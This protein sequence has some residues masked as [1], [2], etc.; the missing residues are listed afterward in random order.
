M[1]EMTVPGP[2][3]NNPP[4]EE[5]EALARLAAIDPEKLVKVATDEI[6]PLLDLNYPVLVARGEELAAGVAR[7]L[8]AHRHG[9]RYAL[10]G[11][12]DNAATSD[13]LRQLATFAG[14]KG[15]VETTR[16]AVKLPVYEAGK[17]VDGWFAARRDA[18]TAAV[19]HMGN[20]Q[21][22]YLRE[23]A[24]AERARQQA[25]EAAAREEQ[26]RA[27]EAARKAAEEEARIAALAQQGD[28]TIE[29][30][31]Q[32]TDAADAALGTAL[33]M[34]ERAAAVSTQAAAPDRDL[35]RSRTALGTTTTLVD[36][37]TWRLTDMR[38]LCQAVIDGNAPIDFLTTNDSVI[39][40]AVRGKSGRRECPGLLIEN[41]ARARRSAA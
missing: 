8:D 35:I 23:K 7:W 18:I 11:E 40:A 6:G 41:D 21:T 5:D 26:R 4:S 29:D 37:W 25:A 31:A 24:A 20:A 13:F 34:E 3:H 16:R 19:T 32:A 9:T 17:A 22:V 1:D 36:R 14:D 38:A 30:V 27:A 33:A 10:A 2:G 28:A 39:S 12:A 15:E